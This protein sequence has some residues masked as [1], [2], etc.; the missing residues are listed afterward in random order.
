MHISEGQNNFIKTMKES[1]EQGTFLFCAQS[2]EIRT[3]PENEIPPA[4]RVDNYS[5][6]FKFQSMGFSP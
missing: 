3:M 6:Q 2:V 4:M 1:N 5:I